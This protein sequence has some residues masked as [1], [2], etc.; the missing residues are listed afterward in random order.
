MA[1][2]GGGGGVDGVLEVVD[3]L[4]PGDELLRVDVAAWGV[5]DGLGEFD[6]AFE[7]LLG[8]LEADDGGPALLGEGL[9]VELEV[10]ECFQAGGQEVCAVVG[11]AHLAVK[12]ATELLVEVIVQ[13]LVAGDE[14]VG[15]GRDLLAVAAGV[16]EVD[17]DDEDDGQG[18]GVDD[19]LALR[20]G[21]LGGAGVLVVAHV[22][23]MEDVAS[24]MMWV[25]ALLRVCLVRGGAR[26]LA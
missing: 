11:G 5:D 6:L 13:V 26:C 10:G 2:G 4:E 14:G 17:G 24:W 9:E 25:D 20:E 21:A 19:L 1:V 23:R 12:E 7:Q 22:S 16:G 18:D 15:G 3:G 8:L